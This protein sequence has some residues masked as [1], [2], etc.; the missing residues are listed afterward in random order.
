MESS[1]AAR[2][3]DWRALAAGRPSCKAE[4]EAE[5]VVSLLEWCMALQSNS[6]WM[7][8]NKLDRMDIAG[9]SDADGVEGGQVMAGEVGS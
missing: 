9:A 8:G 2:K 5:A 3:V 1:G 7:S 4:R 6:S